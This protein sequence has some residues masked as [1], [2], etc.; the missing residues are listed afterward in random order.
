MRALR[1]MEGGT[2]A[3]PCSFALV[4]IAFGDHFGDLSELVTAQGRLLEQMHSISS[5]RNLQAAAIAWKQNANGAGPHARQK[6]E[7]AVSKQGAEQATSSAQRGQGG[8]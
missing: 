2:A 3:S 1:W 4:T 5:S 6:R 8:D 7:G